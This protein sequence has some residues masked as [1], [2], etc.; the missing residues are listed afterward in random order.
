MAKSPPYAES[1]GEQSRIE[2][3]G[4]EVAENSAQSSIFLF[5]LLS[6]ANGMR[7]DCANFSGT[8]H[9]IFKNKNFLFPCKI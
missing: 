8:S 1:I 2:G 9:A 6:S 4:A 5:F 3:G 7:N